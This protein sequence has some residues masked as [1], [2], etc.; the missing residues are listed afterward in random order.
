MSRWE[1][2]RGSIQF[3]KKGFREVSVGLKAVQKKRMEKLLKY[4]QDAYELAKTVKPA[5]RS[6]ALAVGLFDAVG[7]PPLYVFYAEV[8]GGYSSRYPITDVEKELIS[9]ELQR[10]KNGGLT[11]PRASA[12]KVLN[13]PS[14]TIDVTED[15]TLT[16]IAETFTLEWRVSRNNRNVD[17][18]RN[19]PLYRLC[20]DV[21]GRYKWKRGEGGTFTMTQESLD[22]FSDD[23]SESHTSAYWGPVGQKEKDHERRVQDYAF[24]ISR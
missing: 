18:A 8:N 1:A 24:R 20:F 14:F 23:E 21:L 7:T 9:K 11:K 16:M 22:D 4:A 19:S 2:E 10:G 6:D 17:Q 12:F 13:K 5:S 15:A 3:T